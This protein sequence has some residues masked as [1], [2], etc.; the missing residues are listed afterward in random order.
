MIKLTLKN[1]ILPFFALVFLN[2]SVNSSL[3]DFTILAEEYS[4]SVVNVS[5][6][7]KQKE[8]E[9]QSGQMRQNPPGS[10]FDFFNDERFREFFRNQPQKE[11][12]KELLGQVLLS[13]GMG[14]L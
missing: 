10:P 11:F 12:P 9:N 8:K 1:F 6:E 5:V 3:P 13:Q 7:R 2:T 4:S 14:T